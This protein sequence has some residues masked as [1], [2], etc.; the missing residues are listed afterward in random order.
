MV[1]SK[2][3]DTLNNLVEKQN[4]IFYKRLVII[5]PVLS[6]KQEMDVEFLLLRSFLQSNE[7]MY[8][9]LYYDLSAEEN[10]YLIEFTEQF[11][12][13]LIYLHISDITYFFKLGSF[14]KR[15]KKNNSFIIIGGFTAITVKATD[16]LNLFDSIDVVVRNPESEKVLVRLINGLH[17]NRDLLSLEGI[18]FRQHGMNK[19]L[20]TPSSP[21][22]EN[23][24][25]IYLSEFPE[26]ALSDDDWYPLVIS[27]GCNH[28]CQYCG[29]QV[30]YRINYPPGT[31]FWRG[32]PVKKIVDEIE[33]LIGRGKYKF[34]FYCEQFFNPEDA[35]PLNDYAIEIANEILK[36]KLKPR[37]SLIAKSS[38]LVRNIPGLL[39]LREAGLEMVDIGIDSGLDRFH[40][41]YETGSSVWE[42][43]EIL[44]RMHEHCLHFDISFIFFDPYLTIPEI[45]ENLAFLEKISEFFSHLRMPYSDYLISRVLK[46]VLILKH[47]MPII[48]KLKQDNLV[49]EYPDFSSHPSLQ[50][51][52]PQVEKIYSI[53]KAIDK[54]VIP[55]IRPY[56][57]NKVLIDKNPSLNLFPLKVIKKIVN[58][59][60]DDNPTSIS[61]YI[62]EA[63]S[64]IKKNMHDVYLCNVGAD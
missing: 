42:N 61:R 17:E 38:A 31:N 8:E 5:Y 34:A 15:L 47:G 45:E 22:S 9:M 13:D 56:L 64:Y 52:N 41:M 20:T 11:K 21:L 27:R 33:R 43:L 49:V 39:A 32:R 40:Q 51:K 44:Q 6:N 16:I 62:L 1:F 3:V 14:L 35:S 57:K 36:R 29:L 4:S 63:A 19:I 18:T 50:F 55:F 30:P 54:S 12:E 26:Q 23:L 59:V 58:D 28:D 48:Q 7:I 2:K 46:N 37:L 24:D 53:Y 25:D 10:S 60:V